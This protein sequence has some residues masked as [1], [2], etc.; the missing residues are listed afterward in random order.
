MF[1]LMKMYIN[2]LT[3]FLKTNTGYSSLRLMVVGTVLT[4]C[5]SILII[6]IG[7]TCRAIPNWLEATAAITA[8]GGIIGV[9][10]WGK[11][12]DNKKQ[13]DNQNDSN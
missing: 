8:I 5:I 3:A 1:F 12:S 7:E 11:N 4:C 9:A 13:K 6:V 2:K 10:L